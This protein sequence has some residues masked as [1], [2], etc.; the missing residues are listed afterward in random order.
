MRSHF[1]AEFC[2]LCHL[3]LWRTERRVVST[4]V[5][6][7]A[8]KNTTNL[9]EILNQIRDRQAK[10]G[11]RG[12]FG[13]KAGVREEVGVG[14][15]KAGVREEVG[16]GKAGVREEV[17]VGGG[18][19]EVPEGNPWAACPNCKCGDSSCQRAADS[20]R[21]FWESSSFGV[22]RDEPERRSQHYTSLAGGRQC[23]KARSLDATSSRC[24]GALR[25]QRTDKWPAHLS[26]AGIALRRSWLQ[27]ER[28]RCSIQCFVV[29]AGQMCS[30]R[31]L[32][33]N[34]LENKESVINTFHRS[35][36]QRKKESACLNYHALDNRRTQTSCHLREGPLFPASTHTRP[37]SGELRHF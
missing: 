37:I 31:A 16:G 10:G 1:R 6:T 34:G 36:A 4:Q 12:I 15:G 24:C 19:A 13:G 14:G 18:K 32:Q 30:G 33:K 7:S 20:Q 2:A 11:N 17:G 22:F 26:L 25:P 28:A 8:R 21:C 35:C 23:F 3:I 5:T 9:I 29:R 27:L